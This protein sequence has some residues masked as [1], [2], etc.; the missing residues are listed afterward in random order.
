MQSQLWLEEEAGHQEWG[1]QTLGPS[2]VTYL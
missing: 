1:P 2:H